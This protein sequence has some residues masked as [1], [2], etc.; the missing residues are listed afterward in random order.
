MLGYLVL[1]I[2][3]TT[4]QGVNLKVRTLRIPLYLKALDFLDRHY[5]YK[6]LV[7]TVT[8]GAKTDEERA[9]KL[10]EWTHGNIRKNPESLPVVD[11]HAWH[12]IIRGYGLDDQFQD[13]FT[14]LCNYAGL[15]AFFNRVYSE[16]KKGRSLSFVKLDDKWGVFDAYN[17][18]YFKNVNGKIANLD[19]LS[20]GNWRAFNVGGGDIPNHYEKLFKNLNSDRF[21]DWTFSRAAIQSPI[22][23]FIYWL[24]GR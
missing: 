24:N 1:N 11:D 7:K 14:T 4:R 19:D 16:D 21:G 15:D 12:I 13:V 20:S 5:N 2:E 22:R 3:T 23:R 9:I 6:M 18:V 17:G 10:L 8:A